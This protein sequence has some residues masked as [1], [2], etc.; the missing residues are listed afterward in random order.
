MNPTTTRYIHMPHRL[1]HDRRAHLGDVYHEEDDNEK[2]S[3]LPAFLL[4]VY[5]ARCIRWNH[6]LFT[7]MKHTLESLLE[8]SKTPEGIQQIRI[9]VAEL[10]GWK[11]FLLDNGAQMMPPRWLAPYGEMVYSLATMPKYPEDLNA[12]HEVEK[13]AY[14]KENAGWSLEYAEALRDVQFHSHDVM[15]YNYSWHATAIQ[16]CIAMILTLQKP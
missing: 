7:V 10:D 9:M 1:N 13:M 11:P 15:E 12:V 5:L 14:K 2:P 4:W 8:L 6:S 16:R 3:P